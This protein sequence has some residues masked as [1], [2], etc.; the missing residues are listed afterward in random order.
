MNQMIGLL[1]ELV[2]I[3]LR[4]REV[5]QHEGIIWMMVQG[6]RDWRE[7]LKLYEKGRHRS[8]LGWVVDD[9]KK[10]VTDA[11]PD[12]GPHCRRAAYDVAI[13][14]GGKPT[15]DGI[16]HL[17]ERAGFLGEELGLVWGGRFKHIR[18]LGHF[19]LKNWREYGL[20]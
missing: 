3:A 4:H 17:Y 5:C 11:L 1:P 6:Y 19:E 8:P 2:Q 15:W 20:V 12:K 7:Q 16:D 9:R 10:C 14:I 18:D 13:L